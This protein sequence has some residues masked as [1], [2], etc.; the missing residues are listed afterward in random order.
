MAIIREGVCLSLSFGLSFL[1]HDED[2]D[3][4]TTKTKQGQENEQEE[5]SGYFRKQIAWR[6]RMIYNPMY[7]QN[8]S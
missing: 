7:R 8:K 4:R 2:D 6:R 5:S 1:K 3:R